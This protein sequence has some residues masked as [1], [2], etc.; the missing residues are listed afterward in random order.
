MKSKKSRKI[1]LKD[2][3]L[4]KIRSSSRRIIKLAYLDYSEKLLLQQYLYLEK[5]RLTPSQ[6]KRYTRLSR[7]KDT[8]DQAFTRSIC[9][10]F[11]EA[12]CL[13]YQ[14]AVEISIIEPS[15][16]PIDLDMV[17]VPGGK[18]DAIEEYWVPNGGAWFCLKCYEVLK[19]IKFDHFDY[20]DYL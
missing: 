2:P 1:I 5:G 10:C 20:L 14:E 7:E 9:T 19:E 17:W 18:H 8:L 16:R 11:R 3:K 12:A 6:E 4:R 13:S 15:D